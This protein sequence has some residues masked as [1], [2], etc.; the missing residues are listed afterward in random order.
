MTPAHMELRGGQQNGREKSGGWVGRWP[1]KQDS[2]NYNCFLNPPI[3]SSGSTYGKL[4]Q[5]R[6]EPCL[7]VLCSFCPP[8]LLRGHP[9]LPSADLPRGQ[10]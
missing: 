4:L 10:P 8:G 9:L 1:W 2:V 6:V 3:L 5:N 7:H